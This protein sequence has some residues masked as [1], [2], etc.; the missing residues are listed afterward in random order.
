M[1]FTAPP[2]RPLKKRHIYTKS[3][4]LTTTVQQYYEYLVVVDCCCSCFLSSFLPFLL[5][6]F[7]HFFCGVSFYRAVVIY[8]CYVELPATPA[9]FGLSRHFNY[10]ASPCT[11]HRKHLE[12][13]PS[14][15]SAVDCTRNRTLQLHRDQRSAGQ[16]VRSSDKWSV[17]VRRLL[18][19]TTV[20]IL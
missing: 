13:Y 20:L 3:L 8:Y 2:A 17:F 10:C 1:R 7:C 18:G 19:G 5:R 4:Q 15:D 6:F 12:K 11:Q 14:C 9:R 16:H